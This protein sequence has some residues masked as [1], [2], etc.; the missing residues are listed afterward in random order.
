MNNPLTS[1]R[2]YKLKL[3]EK[4]EAVIKRMR[5]KALYFDQ[6][7][8]RSNS[9]KNCFGLKSDKCPPANK[10]LDN[11]EKD[12][13]QLVNKIKFKKV[14]CDFQSKLKEDI[15]EISSSN[16]TLTP[17]DKTS[18]YYR[19]TTEKYNELLQNSITKTYKKARNSNISKVI[20][21]QGKKIAN[22]KDVLDRIKINGEEESYITLKDHKPNFLHNPTT[23]LINPAKNE[24]G[25]ISKI[26]VSKINQNLRKAL[27]LNQWDNT[28]TVINWFKNIQDKNK[29][30]F[31]IFDIKDFY[32]S[33]SKK[34]LDNALKFA[35]EH[36]HINNEDLKIIQHARKS[37][38]YNKNIPWQKKDTNLFDVAMGSYDGAE[39]CD[40]T[41][42]FHLYQIS[43]K[44]NKNDIGL[45]RDDGLA[46]FKNINGHEAD[47][48]RKE[49]QEIFKKNGLFLEIDCNL[50][51]VNYLDVTFDLTTGNYKPFRKPNDETLYIHAKSNHP[52]NIIKQLP[53]SIET[54]LSNLSSTKE[55]FS[56]AS[57]HYQQALDKSGY[58]HKLKYNPSKPKNKEKKNTRKRNITWFNPP[59][60]QNVSTNVGKYFLLLIP[61][62][63]PNNHKYHKIF[64]KNTMKISYSC[65]PNMTAIIN[66][67]NKKLMTTKIQNERK[68]NCMN[69]TICPLSNE[70]L[71]TNIIY[72][73]KITSNLMNYKP[74]FYYGTSE[75]TFK[76][77]YANH[78]KSFNLSQY[79]KD[80]ELSN[81][82]WRLKLLDAQPKVTYSILK[83][84]PP[85]KRNGPCY[86]CL[87]EKLFILEHKGDDLLNQ[88]NELVSK[89]R[90]VNKFKLKNYK[91]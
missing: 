14:S 40:L 6:N 2:Q 76:T 21:E 79:Q 24:I 56:E 36:T 49:F 13:Y 69:K 1:E 45:Y 74:K 5:W 90:H 28:T 88:R 3:V 78:K 38:L 32:P 91:T 64:N 62:H 47:K 77:R 55:I 41:G 17:A 63:F 67:H 10:L 70:C 75:G 52:S 81:E 51:T 42:L 37:L 58:K 66:T 25:R 29:Y 43:R 26:I 34:L 84:C 19:L 68:C 15:K 7:E 57:R 44:F 30:K 27:K 22:K 87:N 16:K 9:S 35:N 54:R 23:R 50:K 31:M 83:R 61:K 65:M 86:L 73:A 12:L 8:E 18:N 85:T 60:S 80:T 48:I 39:I 4:I 82:F 72:K 89:C 46:V 53:K 33:I 11:F 59:F 71:T 20:N